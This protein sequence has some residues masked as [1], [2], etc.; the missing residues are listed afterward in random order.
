MALAFK[1][2]GYIVDALGKGKQSIIIRKGGISEDTPDFTIKG[3][4]FLL[5]PT[6]FHQ[7]HEMIKSE[8]LPHLNGDQ[9]QIA[10]ENKV[11]ILY[12][13]EIAE[14]KLIKDFS[15]LDKLNEH[16][17]WKKEVIEERFNRWEKS[18]HLLIV[19]IHKLFKPAE[20]ELKPQYGGCKSWVELEE[21]IQL[22]GEPVIY[23][24]IKGTYWSKH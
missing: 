6:Q 7:A 12:Y 23:D 19:Q 5:F 22:V 24:P 15:V 16:H 9:Y 11:K 4:K 18:A 2:W 13:A 14:A 8:W 3:T 1:E 20:I 21:N 10:S 17:A